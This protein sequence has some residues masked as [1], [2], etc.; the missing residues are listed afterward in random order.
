MQLKDYLHKRDPNVS[1][2][3]LYIC[4]DCRPVLNAK[5][6]AARCLLNG[7]FTEP[8]PEELA[9]LS[10]LETQ[11]IQRGTIWYLHRKGSH[12]QSIKSGQRNN[13]F[14]HCQCKT[15]WIGWMR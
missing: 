5:N 9:N 12:L 3:K 8:V 10:S 2:K 1:T 15:H 4:K 7:L 11:F 6:I 14:Y 13:V